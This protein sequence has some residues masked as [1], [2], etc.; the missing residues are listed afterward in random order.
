MNILQHCEAFR[1]LLAVL[2]IVL[3]LLAMGGAHAAVQDGAPERLDH[4]RWLSADGG[5]SQVGA[6]AHG[7]D[8]YLWL[9]TNDSLV[10]FD[11]L[12]FRPQA[13]EARGA[14]VIV[15]SLLARGE[16]LWVGLRSG[17]VAP[18]R[19]GR[20]LARECGPGAPGGVVFGLA[21]DRRGALW[22]AAGDGLA[23]RLDGAWRRFG[24]AQGFDDGGAHAVFVDR[25]GVLWAASERRL[26]YLRDGADRFVDAG[27]ALEGAGQ[28]AQAPDGALW[29]SERHGS[30]LHRVMPGSGTQA[31]TRIDAPATA[32]AFDAAGGLWIGLMGRGLLHVARPDGLA[33]LAGATRFTA[34][35]GL[36]SD[37]VSKLHA[38]GAGNLWVGTNAGLDRF[39]PRILAP[40]AF[41]A[42][43]Q[44]LALAAGDD[45]SL[46]G[47][48][49]VG[50]A[51]RLQDG[52]VQALAMPAP[53]DS[54]MRDADGA[55]WMAG[56]AGIWRSRGARL[57]RVAG[58]P[59]AGAR[60]RVRAMA[61]DAQGRLWV[62]L[63]KAGLFRHAAG[64]WERMPASSTRDSQRMPVS[65][66]AAPDGWLWF[67]YR[68]GLLEAR[69]GGETLRWTTDIGHV[70]ALAHHAGRTWIGGQHGLAWVE[71]GR[72]RR[73]PLPDDGMFDNVY[74][75]VPVDGGAGAGLWL[76]ARAGIFQLEAA[77]LGR[78][79]DT[80]GYRLR[81]RSFDALGGLANDPH[82]V[83]P[84]PTAVRGGDGRLWFSTSGGVASLDPARLPP[85]EP[86]P[87]AAIEAVS[88]DGAEVSLASPL[89]LG[90]EAQRI[91][92][93]YTAPSLDAPERLS[94]RYR[95]D[96]FDT[97]WLDAGRARQAIYTGLAPGD[98]RFRLVALN[99]D[100]VPSPH[101]AVFVF[102][103]TQAFYRHPLFLLG[104]GLSLLAAMWL[105]YRAAARRAAERVRDRLHERHRERE[106]IAR[107]LHD[108]LLQGVHGLV[109]RFQAAADMLP[110]EMP[111]RAHMEQALARAD[112]VLVE[113]R[114]RVRELRG[115][116]ADTRE[117]HEALA[118]AG[119]ELAAQ[120]GTRF[121]FVTAGT[122]RAMQPAILDEVHRIGH[123]ALRNACA[124]ARAGQ[125]SVELAYR[126]AA[127][128]LTVTDDGIGIDPSWLA[129]PGRP[130]HWG[131]RGMRERAERIGARLDIQGAG[132]KNTR[133]TRVV[134]T[135]PARIAYRRRRGAP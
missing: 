71:A 24:P 62:S 101:E 107:E 36:S 50:T 65:A 13:P 30:R 132:Q 44:N 78:A 19:P 54:A 43:A 114:D 4:R 128:I 15:S 112:A 72:L 79:L 122:P 20:A 21:Q 108:T 59:A 80:P 26:Y 87:V 12:R 123:E 60:A 52:R 22:A 55:V 47:G 91:A 119:D 5:P 37:F 67:G 48:P 106:R 129:G 93:D 28:I 82:Q 96:G 6:I 32:L 23:R 88:V 8:G 51:L 29:L 75:I 53:V 135:L 116:P 102:R 31:T 73:L 45:G 83:L 56:P 100:G 57:E 118:S 34:Q 39:R 27:L 110:P 41:P 124:H 70:T 10:R 98:Y 69:R 113:G 95:L 14:P 97:R 104:A 92:I 42:G 68:D 134:L 76:H 3:P 127:F 111:A 125:V 131:L 9:G 1:R 7:A 94:F 121:V 115:G 66:L 103:V 63:D 18:L 126:R 16:A 46:W 109:L 130:G 84:L 11:G 49:R 89:S 90:P 58:L 17:G 35:Q 40:A 99:K 81:Y 2:S 64:R 133:G 85:A 25:D 105:A 38:D 61:R 86:G 74:A 33:A 120:G 77:E 117:L